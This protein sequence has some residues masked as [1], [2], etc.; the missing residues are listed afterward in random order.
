[1]NAYFEDYDSYPAQPGTIGA[2]HTLNND[3]PVRDVVAELRAVVAEIT[4]Q[5]AQPKPRMGFC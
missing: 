5:P 2:Q 4:R 3:K 1:M